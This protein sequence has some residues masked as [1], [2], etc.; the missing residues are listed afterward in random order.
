[1]LVNS[2]YLW[3]YAFIFLEYAFFFHLS[4]FIFKTPLPAGRGRG[5]VLR[6]LFF[7]H[8][9]IQGQLLY[10]GTLQELLDAVATAVRR[11]LRKEQHAQALDVLG[12]AELGGGLGALLLH[13]DLERAEAVQLHA[14]GVLHLVLHD[15]HEFLQHCH[16][17]GAFHGT[18]A[19][20]DLCQLAGVNHCGGYGAGIPFATALRPRTLVLM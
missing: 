9:S 20:D 4:F 8:H 3:E 5:W 12:D 2:F 16:H 11:A 1:M 14:L 6:L 13:S 18:V 7:L 19:L 10:A 17:V 15:L